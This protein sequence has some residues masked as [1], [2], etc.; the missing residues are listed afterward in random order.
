M[1]FRC[2]VIHLG[3]WWSRWPELE[4][5]ASS[6]PFAVI[7]MAQLQAHTH[8]RNGAR[9]LAAKTHLM[10]L[11]YRHEY[12]RD[13]NQPV[14]SGRLDVDSAVGAGAGIRTSA[15]SDRKGA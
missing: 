11:L 5:L 10:G 2:P 4:A 15:G 9:R 7:V 13:D 14:P 6:N 1:Q 8:H 3:Q 12:G